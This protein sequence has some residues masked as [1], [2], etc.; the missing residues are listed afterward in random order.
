M[1]ID[2]QN[3]FTIGLSSKRLKKLSLKTP[4]HLRCEGN[5]QHTSNN[6]K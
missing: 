2:G 6:V 3:S 1:L 4:Q 5:R